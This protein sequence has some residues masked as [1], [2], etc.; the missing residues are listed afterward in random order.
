[1]A[2]AEAEALASLYLIRATM[3]AFADK[4]ILTADEVREA[5]DAGIAQCTQAGPTLWRNKEAATIMAQIR[6]ADYGQ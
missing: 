6:D 5:I 2:S 1:M 3:H 4:K